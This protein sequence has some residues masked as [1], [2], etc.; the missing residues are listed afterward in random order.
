[1]KLKIAI[2]TKSPPKVSAIEEAVTNCPYFK[3]KEIE[4]I[5]LKVKSD[6]SDM[7]TSIEENMLGAKNRA[8]NSSKEVKADFYIGMEGGTN[9][10]GEKSYLF[11]VIYLLNKNGE[12]HFGISNMMEVPKYFHKKIYYEKQELGPILSEVTGIENASK[13]N[14]A[15]GAWSDDILTRKNQFIYAFNSAIPPFFNKYYK[16]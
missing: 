15:F 1:M 11:G 4:F 12:G 7:P 14:G 5:T 10:L 16:L 13:K 3:D 2:G 8:I 6:I 9:F